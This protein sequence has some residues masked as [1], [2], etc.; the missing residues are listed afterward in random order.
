VDL[1]RLSTATVALAP[2]QE[3][4]VS[5]WNLTLLIR[6]TVLG[7]RYAL[8][9]DKKVNLTG[10]IGPD[11]AGRS[12]RAVR[13]VPAFV[14]G[15]GGRVESRSEELTNPAL[16]I[17]WLEGD[18][19]IS[20]Q[21]LFQRPDLRRFSHGEQDDLRLEFLEVETDSEGN[22]VFHLALSD[23]VSGA[24]LKTFSLRLG[25]RISLAELA[26]NPDGVDSNGT[27]RYSVRLLGTESLQYTVLTVSYNPMIPLIYFGAIL[28]CAAICLA[29]YTRKV[30]LWVWCGPAQQTQ[31]AVQYAP[32]RSTLTAGVERTLDALH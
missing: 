6:P 5:D 18:R 26:G 11:R 19:T 12:I 15:P 22:R 28:A 20:T 13:F 30:T 10:T 7:L 9:D 1:E 24:Q 32:E 27:S 25:D 2:G 3:L 14:L 8:D 23:P 17:E 29:F 21:W 31:V 16:Q 4:P